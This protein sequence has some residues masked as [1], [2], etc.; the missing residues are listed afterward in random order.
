MTMTTDMGTARP[1]PN[2]VGLVFAIVQGR[3]A[4]ARRWMR[5]RRDRRQLRE[6]P[7]HML[8]DIGIS[9]YEI[10]AVT[11]YGNSRGMRRGDD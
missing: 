2:A 9:R 11:E 8:R 3:I 7:D 10:D 4:W 5:I 1:I 6:M